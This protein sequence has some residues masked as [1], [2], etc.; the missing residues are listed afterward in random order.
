MNTET[1]EIC[2]L[3]LEKRD[4]NH[5]SMLVREIKIMM[6]LKNEIGFAR[7]QGYGKNMDY[8]FVAM[9]YLG[10]NMESLL[11]KCGGKFTLSTVINIF[12]QSFW[13]LELLH[14]K[15]L[16][17]RDL[18]PENF[19]IGYQND[20]DVIYLIDFGLAKYYIKSDGSNL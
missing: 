11:K 7:I 10:R 16:L 1:M 3:K 5:S 2:A 19:V 17:H 12:E 15:N 18:K 6:E 13:R 14:S 4:N 20:F 9:T 8:N